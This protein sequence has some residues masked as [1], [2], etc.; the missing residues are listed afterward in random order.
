MRLAPFLTVSLALHASALVYPIAFH[1]WREELPIEVTILPMETEAGGGSGSGG[2]RGNLKSAPPRLASFTKR[3]EEADVDSSENS[4]AFAHP[5]AIE[6]A[7]KTTDENVVLSSLTSRA[8]V[9]S[10]ASGAG[11]AGLG[12]GTAG[13]GFGSTGTGS[14]SGAVSG[15]S[16]SGSVFNQARYNDT[17]KPIYPEIARREGREGRVLLRVLIDEQGKTRAIE[18]NRS[19][20]IVALDNAATDALKRWRFYPARAGDKPIQSWVMIPIDFRLTDEKN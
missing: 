20:G 6:V 16:Q 5:S 19:S 17:P 10:V 14:G 18:V 15:S 12:A 8:E 9:S 13:S 1:G 11:S 4:E 7:A 2:Q 3:T